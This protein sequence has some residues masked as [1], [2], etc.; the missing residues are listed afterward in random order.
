[1][2]SPTDQRPPVAVGH[3]R[4][5]VVDVGAAAR[6]LETVGLR[7]IVTRGELAVLESGWNR[8]FHQYRRNR[9]AAEKLLAVGEAPRDPGLDTLELA[10]FTTAASVILNLDEVVTK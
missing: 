3:V 9:A 7:P 6:W 1:M 10:A 4:L 5:N 8:R 2:P